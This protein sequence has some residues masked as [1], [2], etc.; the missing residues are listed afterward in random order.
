MN[1]PEKLSMVTR[2]F[3]FE[4]IIHG[5][6]AKYLPDSTKQVMSGIMPGMQDLTDKGRGGQVPQEKVNPASQMP[7][8]M[9]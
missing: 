9:R 6:A 5:D 3:L 7:M 8:S 2:D 1:D 4:P